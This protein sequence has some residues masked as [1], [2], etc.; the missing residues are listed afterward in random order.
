MK[1]SICVFLIVLLSTQAV[2]ALS[3]CEVEAYA[4]CLQLY[5]S[6]IQQRQAAKKLNMTKEEYCR[7]LA[8]EYCTPIYE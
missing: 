3:R 4:K 7:W 8:E 2:Y 1:K 5:D 6:S